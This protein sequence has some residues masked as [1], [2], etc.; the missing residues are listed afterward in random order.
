VEPECQG[1]QGEEIPGMGSRDPRT[2]SL[3]GWP[4][5]LQTV[6][7]AVLAPPLAE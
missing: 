5:G 3:K 6:G 4:K 2:T 7:C 1:D